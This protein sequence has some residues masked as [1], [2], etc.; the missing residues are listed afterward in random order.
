MARLADFAPYN[1]NAKAARLEDVEG[2]EVMVTDFRLVDGNYGEYAFVDMVK[3]DGT[4]LTVI[5]GA[6]AI[7]EALKAAKAAQALP[8]P[9]KF[10]RKKRAW[11][12]E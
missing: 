2:Q 12:I 3:E 8:L 1:P 10:V 9:A 7:L 11:T 5:T 6:R 4:A